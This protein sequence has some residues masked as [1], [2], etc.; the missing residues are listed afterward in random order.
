MER[1]NYPDEDNIVS[2]WLEILNVTISLK[3]NYF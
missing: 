3:I 2:V 1:K